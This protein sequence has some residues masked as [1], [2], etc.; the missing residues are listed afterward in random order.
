MDAFISG[1]SLPK[2]LAS[3]SMVAFGKEELLVLGGTSPESTKVKKF[4]NDIY[5]LRCA[6]GLCSW[7]KMRKKMDIGR[8]SFVVFPLR[9]DMVSCGQEEVESIVH[10]GR[11]LNTIYHDDMFIILNIFFFMQEACNEMI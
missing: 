6:S 10:S 5:K 2:K 3:H 4:E 8:I 9:D 11:K 1:P 7:S